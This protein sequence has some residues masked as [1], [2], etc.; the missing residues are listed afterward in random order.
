MSAVKV[1][2][3]DT[4]KLFKTL[5][6]LA[7]SADVLVGIPADKDDRAG[8]SIGNASIGYI[9][10]KGSPK[11][12]IPPRPFLEPGVAKVAKRCASILGVGAAEAL[13]SFDPNKVT[14]AQNKAGL[15][16]QNSVRA[17][18]TEGDGF[19]PLA[20]STLAARARRGVTRTKPLIDTG[21]LRT[22]ITYVLRKRG[23]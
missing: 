3:D 17:T 15:I 22:S 14:V 11:Q 4:A 9:N 8:E 16:A 19:A 23:A 18:L 7:N 6:D 20:K 5:R 13:T 12:G 1:V 10:E 2:M 21:S